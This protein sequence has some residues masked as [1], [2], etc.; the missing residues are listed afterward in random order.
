MNVIVVPLSRKLGSVMT[1]W[2]Q[3]RAIERLLCG[4]KQFDIRSHSAAQFGHC[5]AL[6]LDVGV[7]VLA[8][9]LV[10]P[11]EGRVA[12]HILVNHRW[13]GLKEQWRRGSQPF[14]LKN[15]GVSP[16]SAL[17]LIVSLEEIC[18]DFRARLG[19]IEH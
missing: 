2:H 15:R 11:C 16:F 9:A 13:H 12:M 19:R 17:C 3:S 1:L 10:N 8:L 5:G 4:P 18:W 7:L 14:F 6:W